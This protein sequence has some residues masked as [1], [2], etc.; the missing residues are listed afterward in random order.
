MIFSM[1]YIDWQWHIS[2]MPTGS[3]SRWVYPLFLVP[4]LIS[5]MV[6]PIG[7]KLCQHDFFDEIHRLAMAHIENANWIEISL[8]VPPISC[9]NTNF[10]NGSSDRAETLPA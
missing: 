9:T 2:K 6:H 10:E 5:R 3:R 8:G 4:I 1:K 7:L